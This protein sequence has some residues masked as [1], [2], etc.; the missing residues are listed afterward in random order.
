[1]PAHFIISIFAYLI[2]MIIVGIAY[3]GHLIETSAEWREKH[4]TSEYIDF[5][6][7]FIIICWPIT[8]LPGALK[9]NDDNHISF[10]ETIFIVLEIMFWFP[11][12]IYFIQ[13][14]LF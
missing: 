5:V 1:M 14:W 13:L 12:F 3:L 4:P 9:A 8:G 11:I 2:F 10:I 6:L 7:V